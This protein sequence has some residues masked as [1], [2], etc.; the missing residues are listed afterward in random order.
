MRHTQVQQR[1]ACTR[2]LAAGHTLSTYCPAKPYFFFPTPASPASFTFF[3]KAPPSQHVRHQLYGRDCVSNAGQRTWVGD[4]VDVV[5]GVAAAA[6]I[7][8]C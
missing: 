3:D 6:R 5:M 1:R 2:R 8:T 4:Q 7:C